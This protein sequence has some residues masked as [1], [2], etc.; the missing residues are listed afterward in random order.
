MYVGKLLPHDPKVSI[1]LCIPRSGSLS[2]IKTSVPSPV[3]GE[4]PRPVRVWTTPDRTQ[5]Y[6]WALQSAA[7]ILPR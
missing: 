5:N 6:Q 3:P 1:V 4:P 7:A 2:S